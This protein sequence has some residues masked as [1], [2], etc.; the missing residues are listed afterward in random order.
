MNQIYVLP[1][2]DYIKKLAELEAA[3]KSVKVINTTS[4]SGDFKGLSPFVLGPCKTYV[5]SIPYAQNFENLWQYSKVYACHIIPGTLPPMHGN[6]WYKWREE[7]WKNPRAVRYPM[8]KGAKPVYSHWEGQN[9]TYV[10]ARKKIYALNYFAN[11]IKTE[12][13]KRLR[14]MYKIHDIIL[15]DY[16]AYDH[17]AMGRTLVDVINDPDKKC[18]H[19][20]I[21]AMIL[22]G[23]LPDCVEEI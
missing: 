3:R 6:E 8:G 14:E 17:Q 23:V 1:L 4:G 12:A 15:L 18:G 7:G 9:L 2:W 10:Q 11:V 20:F 13:F 22:T 19:A 5:P 16:D 21:L